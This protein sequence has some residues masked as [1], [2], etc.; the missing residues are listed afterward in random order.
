MSQSAL[1]LEEQ[2]RQLREASVVRIDTLTVEAANVTIAK[3]EEPPSA[4]MVARVRWN[5][6]LFALAAIL[7][8][9]WFRLHL[10]TWATHTVLFG[11]ATLWAMWQFL[12]SVAKKDLGDAGDELR[13]RFLAREQTREH[14]VFAIGIAVIL[15]ATTSSFY[16]QLDDRERQDVRIEVTKEPAKGETTGV[17]FMPHLELTSGARIGGRL[18]VPRFRAEKL[19]VTVLEPPGYTFN[20]NPVELR[21][22]SAA[23]FK[24]PDNFTKK[25]LHAVRVVPGVT[26]ADIDAPA[27]PPAVAVLTVTVGK[28]QFVVRDFQFRTVYLGVQDKGALEQLAEAQTDDR[29]TNEL[30]A[31]LLARAVKAEERDAYLTDWKKA[32]RVQPSRDF[33][34]GETVVA[35]LTLNGVQIAASTPVQIGAGEI[36]TVFVEMP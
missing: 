18:F 11:T 23:R 25:K 1:T 31:H 6:A 5:A 33:A 4:E 9:A 19:T 36:T 32:P 2:Q 35:T 3:K 22:W 15:L 34:E 8:Y 27:T 29:F 14:L 21:A 28:E 13:K 26:L 17:P 12:L 7:L 16:V 10:E 24:F 20:E 30:N